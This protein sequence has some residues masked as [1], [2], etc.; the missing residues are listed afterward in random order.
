[1]VTLGTNRFSI[2]KFYNDVHTAVTRCTWISQQTD[3]FLMQHELDGFHH[4][5][6]VFTA[7]YKL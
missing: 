2:Q 3:F 7:R 5:W 4:R 6:W 1:V